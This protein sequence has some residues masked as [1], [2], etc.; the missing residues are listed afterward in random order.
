[1][2]TLDKKYQ[3]LLSDIIAFGVEKKDRTGTGT[4]SEFGH[5]IR[6]KMSEGFP[7]LTTKKMAW[8]QIVSELLWF[9]T[10]QTNISFLHKHNNHIWDGDAYKNYKTK[11]EILMG[12]GFH[13]TLLSHQE[14][15]NKIKTD[16][17]FAKTWGDLG[18][19][20]GKQ[21]RKWDGKNGRIDQIDDLVKELKTNPDS[22]RLMVSAWNVGELDQMILPPCH[23]GFQ[24]YTTELSDERRYNIWFNNNYE[25]GM[26]RFFDPNNLPDF[27]NSYYTPTPKRA[28]SLMWNQRS[29]DTFLGLPF[30][31]ASY[32][33]LLHIIA[34]EVNMVPDELIGNLG[35]VHLYSNHIEQAKEQ[36]SREPFDLPTLKTNAKMDGICC[37]EPDDF[38][39][40]G[41]Q[42]HS[43]IKAPLSN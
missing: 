13:G 22:R 28:I 19:I 33:L 1:M 34:N 31:I 37:N 32:G 35:D 5:Q 36:I 20:Y 42:Y 23:Y 3:Q 8:K 24:V 17:E 10:G 40:E 7:L 11:T 38:I 18:P 12:H 39:L 15:I 9:L 26:E 21:W 6:H 30:N 14:F 2:N 29:V 25:T 43:T 27:D 4:I 41:Y 16:V